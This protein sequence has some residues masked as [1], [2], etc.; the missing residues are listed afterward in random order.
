MESFAAFLR[1]FTRSF[2]AASPSNF[3]ITAIFPIFIPSAKAHSDAKSDTSSSPS[4][5]LKS[6]AIVAAYFSSPATESASS[7][8]SAS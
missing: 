6:S 8:A 2:S 3:L 1:L 7:Y 4:N 5:I